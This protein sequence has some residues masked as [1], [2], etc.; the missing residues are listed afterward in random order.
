MKEAAV[1]TEAAA[2]A[3]HNLSRTINGVHK[4]ILVNSLIRKYN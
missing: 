1:R 3:T 4:T 2:T